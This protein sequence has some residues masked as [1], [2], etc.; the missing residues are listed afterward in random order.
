MKEGDFFVGIVEN[1]FVHGR[2]KLGRLTGFSKDIECILLCQNKLDGYRGDD[3]NIYNY[4]FSWVIYREGLEVRGNFIR[5]ISPSDEE[6]FL[7]IYEV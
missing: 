1:T 5:G 4:K 6:L 7:F 3:P 2:I